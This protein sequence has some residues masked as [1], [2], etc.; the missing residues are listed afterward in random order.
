M[1]E[2]KE[3]KK[4]DVGKWVI[5]NKKENEL[6]TEQTFGRMEKGKIKC[7]NDKFIFVVYKCDNQW[8]RFQDFTG[9][10]TSPEDLSYD[11]TYYIPKDSPMKEVME[12][13]KP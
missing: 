13:I 5:Y 8:D 1:I 2:I 12:A 3:L 6:L 7:W 11:P 10:A 4:E 9:C